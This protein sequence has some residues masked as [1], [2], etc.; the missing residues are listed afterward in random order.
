[1]SHE[2]PNGISVME[3]NAENALEEAQRQKDLESQALTP[4]VAALNDKAELEIYGS[5]D[6]TYVD[7][8][9]GETIASPDKPVKGLIEDMATNPRYGKTEDE[10]QQAVEVYQNEVQN[11]LDNGYELA[12]AKL[13]QDLRSKDQARIPNLTAK[14]MQEGLDASAANEKARALYEKA[15]ARRLQL[16]KENGVFTAEDYARL[17]NSED[18][19][20]PEAPTP[21]AETTPVDEETTDT[22]EIGEKNEKQKDLELLKSIS[23][24]HWFDLKADFEKRVKRTLEAAGTDLSD[25]LKRQLSFEIRAGILDDYLKKEN[26]QEEFNADQK[27]RILNVLGLSQGMFEILIEA[28][29]KQDAP[30][31]PDEITEGLKPKTEIEPDEPMPSPVDLPPGPNRVKVFFR[32]IKDA[33]VSVFI[34]IQ[35]LGAGKHDNTSPIVLAVPPGEIPAADDTSPEAKRK[36]RCWPLALGIGALALAGGYAAGKYGMPWT[37]GGGGGSATHEGLA[38]ASAVHGHGAGQL[39]EH[40]DAWNNV[41]GHRYEQSVLPNNLEQGPLNGLSGAE[42]IVDKNT[43]FPIVEHV[44]YK[45][46]GAY[47]DDTLRQLHSA[48]YNTQVVQNP[49]FDTDSGPGPVGNVDARW[50]TIVTPATQG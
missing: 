39:K 1:M 17:I 42:H 34:W 19:L 45:A 33:P 9:T 40:V 21:E 18:S 48:G 12:Q 13:I 4:E 5:K 30:E 7:P 26:R 29:H 43:G 14:W 36:R 32:R 15:D 27:E 3:A 6:R 8:R 35:T 31:G 20:D 46:N 38:T 11:L 25:G 41:G 23:G 24:E 47:S 2:S 50:T 16:I 37:W 44:T 22:A 10:R 28:A 49:I